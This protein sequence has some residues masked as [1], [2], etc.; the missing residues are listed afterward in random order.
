MD[1]QMPRVDG[2]DATRAIRKFPRTRT[3]PIIAMTANAFMEDKALCLASGMNDFITKPFDPQLLYAAIV[4]W[5]P[6]A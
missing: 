6:V 2:M 4:Q 5:V 3:V 1:M